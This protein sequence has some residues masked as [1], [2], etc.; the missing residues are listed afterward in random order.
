MYWEGV[1]G[2]NEELEL[3]HIL[4]EMKRKNMEDKQKIIVGGLRYKLQN[5]LILRRPLL[6]T[7]Q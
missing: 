7:M 1:I 4:L 5:L 3:S 6:N 2:L